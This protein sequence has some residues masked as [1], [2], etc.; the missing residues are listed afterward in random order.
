MTLVPR[1]RVTYVGPRYPTLPY[2]TVGYVSDVKTATAFRHVWVDFP[3]QS[4]RLQEVHERDL[5]S[6]AIP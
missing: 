6:D 4:P 5:E 2:G 3:S 1:Q